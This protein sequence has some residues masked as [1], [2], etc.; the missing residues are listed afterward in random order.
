MARCGPS[1]PCITYIFQ[2]GF[3]SLN[4]QADF[5]ATGKNYVHCP[6]WR[7]PGREFEG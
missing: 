2:Y 3:A 1:L 7:I 6:G 5:A 4:R